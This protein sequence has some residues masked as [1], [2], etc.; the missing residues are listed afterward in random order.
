MSDSA[1]KDAFMAS[2]P[3]VVDSFRACLPTAAVSLASGRMSCLQP[4]LPAAL[5]QTML[6]ALQVPAR[7][8]RWSLRMAMCS[9]V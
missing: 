5:N 4:E 8:L 2:S 9:G 1:V 3:N 7:I 6:E